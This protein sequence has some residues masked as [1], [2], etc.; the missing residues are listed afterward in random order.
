VPDIDNI[1][2]PLFPIS[3]AARILEISVHTLRMYEREGLIVPFKKES[4]HRLYSKADIE[5]ITCIRNAI[6]KNKI[7]INGIKTIY[8]LIPCWE[9]IKCSAT[10]KG[11]CDAFKSHSHP[12]WTFH[13]TNNLCADNICRDCSVYKDYSEC[14]NLKDK[15]ISII[16]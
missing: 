8:S 5:R 3:V 9:I 12:C 7:S 10:D 11:N 13:H 4:S 14:K 2:T 15:L 16:K 6:N 1:E